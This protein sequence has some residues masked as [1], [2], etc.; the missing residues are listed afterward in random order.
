MESETSTL[1]PIASL[2]EGYEIPV[3]KTRTSERSELVRYFFEHAKAEWGG[4]R[5]LSAAY[6]GSRLS[7]LSILDLYAFKSMCE[8]RARNGYPWGKFFWGALKERKEDIAGS[9]GS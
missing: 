2:F 1:H 5:P 9:W 4:R 6:V 7:F 8:D 3:A